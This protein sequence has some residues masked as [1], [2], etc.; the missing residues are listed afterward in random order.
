M[1]DDPT[2]GEITQSNEPR[3][4]LTHP[5]GLI[6]TGPLGRHSPCLWRQPPASMSNPLS[7]L[8]E[9]A[10]PAPLNCMAP[11]SQF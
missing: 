11:S 6:F 5:T 2:T 1:R 8:L 10:I 4:R 7:H 3:D 9:L